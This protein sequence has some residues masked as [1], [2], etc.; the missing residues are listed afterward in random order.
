VAGLYAVLWGKYKEGQEAK[1]SE[2]MAFP[3]AYKDNGISGQ[4]LYVAEEDSQEMDCD[5]PNGAT[6]EV[7][8]QV[9]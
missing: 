2:V 4:A 5:K 3:L 9:A 1:K 8:S 6:K 7:P